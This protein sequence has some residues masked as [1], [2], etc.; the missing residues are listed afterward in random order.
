L[1]GWDEFICGFVCAIEGCHQSIAKVTSTL[2]NNELIFLIS[3]SIST[4]T[5]HRASL[6]LWKRVDSRLYANQDF[7]LADIP[8]AASEECRL[9][10]VKLRHALDTTSPHE[11]TPPETQGAFD[12]GG[13]QFGFFCGTGPSEK[14]GRG[15]TKGS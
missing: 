14:Q 13:A 7:R 1:S 10:L 9:L 2:A 3:R 5:E 12:A 4:S 6:N 15:N 11:G 8:V